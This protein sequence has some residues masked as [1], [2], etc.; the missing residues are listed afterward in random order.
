MFSG[1]ILGVR[2]L[3]G[4]YLGNFL[5]F[6]VFMNDAE[7]VNTNYSW[8]AKYLALK[9][10]PNRVAY[11]IQF[12]SILTLILSTFEQNGIFMLGVVFCLVNFGD[13]KNGFN[14]QFLLLKRRYRLPKISI[15]KRY[16]TS[17]HFCKVLGV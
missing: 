15:S 10:L 8:V 14:K 11:Q 7:S 1:K 2:T 13:R 17:N 6:Q 12:D 3:L 16:F 9:T 5:C 4:C